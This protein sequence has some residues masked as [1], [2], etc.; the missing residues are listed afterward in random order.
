MAIPDYSAK[1]LAVFSTIIARAACLRKWS[2][3][4]G[5]AGAGS[6]IEEVQ[7]M[8]FRD[9]L[10]IAGNKGEHVKIADFLQAFGVS[11]HASF[12]N[13][14]K[15]SHWLLS[16][17]FVT[18]TAV[19]GRSYPGKFSD[20]EDITL[21]YGAASL[22]HIPALTLNEIDQA[23]DLIVATVLPVAGPLRILAWFLKKFTEAAALPGLNRP[24][25]AAFHYTTEYNGVFGI[26]VLNDSTTVH[27]ELKLLRMLEYAHTKNLMPLKTRRVRVGGLKK[28][29][30]FCAAW[31]NRFQPW[32]LTAYEVRIDLPA[33]D[34][35]GVADGAGNRPTN[36]GEAG[37]GPY[38]RELFN[39]AVNSNCADVVG[40]YD[41]PE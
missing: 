1:D 18:R 20:Q 34:T 26:N 7:C 15:Y 4:L 6:A 40:P 16:I 13:C 3:E 19:T 36:V 11:N 28:T 27:A 38:V 33:E 39:G 41:N 37:F 21:T 10:Y 31:I 2:T 30:A 29:C 35:R 32:M 22:G 17:P 9:S 23:R 14:L 24:P 5:H 8:Q 12:M 25:A